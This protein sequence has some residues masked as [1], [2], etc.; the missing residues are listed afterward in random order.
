MIKKTKLHDNQKNTYKEY[1]MEEIQVMYVVVYKMQICLLVF[2]DTEKKGQL[3]NS[4]CEQVYVILF[5]SVL[6]LTVLKEHQ[7]ICF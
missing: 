1:L 6:W 2:W 7:N 5:L 4:I 3:V